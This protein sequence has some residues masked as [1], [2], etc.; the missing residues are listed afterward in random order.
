MALVDRGL[1]KRGRESST[2]QLPNG[3]LRVVHVANDNQQLSPDAETHV[4]GC[5]YAGTPNA[6]ARSGQLAARWGLAL[7]G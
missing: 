3:K 1:G 4:Q 5:A 7:G 6:R 2:L